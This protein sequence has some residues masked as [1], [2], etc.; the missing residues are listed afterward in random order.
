VGLKDRNEGDARMDDSAAASIITAWAEL[1][2]SLRSA[3]PAC[4]L[5]PP[6]QPAELLAAL[7]VNGVLGPREE[8]RI[9]ALRR[10]RNRVAHGMEEPSAEGAADYLAEVDSLLAALR[11][12][13]SGA[14]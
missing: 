1:E 9:M 10:R 8:E 5:V 3:L 12:P 11:S 14:C 13:S 7:R 2:A 6:T 4:S